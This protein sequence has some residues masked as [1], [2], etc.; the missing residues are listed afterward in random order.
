MTLYLEE[1]GETKLPFDAEALADRVIEGTLDH[2]QCPYEAEVD[3]ILTTDP[4]IREMNLEYRGIDR[5]TDVL[6]FPMSDFETPG[7]FSFLEK[8]PDAFDPESGE[9]LL[10]DI[11]I[12]KD[13]V[14]AQ[15]QEYGHSPEREFSFLITHSVLHLTGY[16]HI[17]EE[18][19]LLMEQTQREILEELQILR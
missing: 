10:G 13:R 5:A 12:S 1:E 3:L 7:D 14:L 2:L 6:S 15:A 17:E 9:L 16:D 8:D 4:Q 18:D 11:V 19:R